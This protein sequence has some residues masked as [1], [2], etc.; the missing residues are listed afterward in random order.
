M[1]HQSG[2]LHKRMLSRLT[3][4]HEQL[5]NARLNLHSYNLLFVSPDF[6][7][8]PSCCSTEN[9][10]R[11]SELM[12]FV[13]RHRTECICRLLVQGWTGEHIMRCVV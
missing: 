2:C 4:T 8:S 5:T 10:T 3:A 7:F 9:P 1:H 11:M 6:L 12:Q 13:W